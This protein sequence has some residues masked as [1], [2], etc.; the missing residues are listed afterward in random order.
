MTRLVLDKNPDSKLEENFANIGNLFEQNTMNSIT[1]SEPFLKT[2]FLTD[3][4]RSL[5]TP[6]IY[7]DFDLLYSGYIISKTI[8]SISGVTLFQPTIG[9]WNKILKSILQ[10]ISQEKTTLIIDSLNGFYNLFYENQYVGRLVN[11]YIMLFVSI[12]KM[13]ESNILLT[14]MV[15]HKGKDQWV[16]SNTGRQVIETKKMTKI[17]LAKKNSH[18][19]LYIRSNNNSEEKLKIGINSELI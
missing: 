8:P 16:L 13:S 10:R 6:I 17:H 11:S 4:I 12:S 1:C 2:V 7:L 15:K 5:K 14:T 19:E 18:L 3:F 9:N